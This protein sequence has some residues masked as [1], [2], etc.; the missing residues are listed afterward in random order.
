MGSSCRF[1]ELGS[2]RIGQFGGR[3]QKCVVSLGKKRFKSF[4]R[5]G[6]LAAQL[7]QLQH[8]LWRNNERRCASVARDGYGLA[9]HGI[10]Q[11]PE[12][13]LGLYGG[14]CDHG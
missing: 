4:Y 9:L 14:D 13:V 10:E 12:S 8:V 6:A 11:L 2:S 1:D 5:A 3:W 7:L